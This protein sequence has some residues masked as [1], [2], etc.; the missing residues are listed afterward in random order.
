[1]HGK[2]STFLASKNLKLVFYKKGF[3]DMYQR[4]II[5]QEKLTTASIYNPTDAKN[6]VLR[7]KNHQFTKKIQSMNVW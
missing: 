4:H 7:C 6:F 1:M 3:A 2:F 5:I